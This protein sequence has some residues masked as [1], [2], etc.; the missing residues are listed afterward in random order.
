MTDMELEEKFITTNDIR[1]HVV[2]AGPQSGPPVILLH[3]FPEFWRGW[4]KQI[5]ALVKAGFRVIVPDQRGYN[6]SDVPKG[7]KAY[8]LPQLGTDIIGLL[9]HF[10]IDKVDLVGHDWGAVVAWSVALTYPQ[11]V[12]RLGILNVPHP[13]VM[14]HFLTHSPRQMLKSWYVGFFQIPAL[15]EWIVKQDN[16]AVG[17][18][19]FRATSQP[20]TFSDEEIAHYKQA[21]TNSGGV[22]GMINWYRALVRYRSPLPADIRLHMPV[23]IQWGKQDA[24]LMHEMAEESLKLCDQGRLIFYDQATHWVQ[25]EAA[26][27]VNHALVDFLQDEIK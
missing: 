6:L 10:G 15:A 26:E 27:Q 14:L 1:L 3:G 2:V 20:G 9:D 16:F 8:A 24:F 25:H 7:V 19:S 11:R 22:T 21:W 13:M 12:R 17:E 5:P 4:L 18:R 23:L